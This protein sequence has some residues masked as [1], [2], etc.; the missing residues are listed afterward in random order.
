MKI[1]LLILLTLIIS[2]SP[3]MAQ[4]ISNRDI[5]EIKKYIGQSRIIG[6]GEEEHFYRESNIDRI[7]II[8]RLINEELINAIVFEYPATG[9]L[10]VNEYIHN[11]IDKS[12]FL[13]AL[14]QFK[15]LDGGPFFDNEEMFSF[16]EW[17]KNRNRGNNTIEVYGMDFYNYIT[18]IENLQ[19]LGN[20]QNSLYKI[21][22]TLD[23]LTYYLRNNPSH[24]TK[25][26]TIDCSI[27]NLSMVKELLS[28]VDTS[29]SPSIRWSANN[30]YNYSYWFTDLNNRDSLMFQS[31]IEIDNTKKKHLIWA[32]NF[33]LQNDSLSMPGFTSNLFGNLMTKKYNDQYFKIGV[34]SANPCEQDN[35]KRVF[36]PA[37]SCGI[38]NKL[39]LIILIQKGNKTTS[40]F[41]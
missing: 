41:D 24:L 12:G 34:M 1:I 35:N 22:Q 14:K 39:D 29:L 16:I 17:L 7:E 38:K 32:A 2:G 40:I 6:L 30:L 36:L 27:E 23:T 4:Q 21:K 31:F 25:K 3:I 15:K 11:K 26:E 9:A 8:K 10:V 37:T 33:H 13:K 28:K 18:A 19:K 5:M 20:P